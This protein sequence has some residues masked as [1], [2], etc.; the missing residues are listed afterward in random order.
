MRITRH[1]V[2]GRLLPVN[3][4]GEVLLLHGWDPA[5]PSAPY[6]FSIGGAPEGVESLAEAACREMREETGLVVAP[7]EL[8]GPVGRED[9]AFDF[10]MWHLVQDQTFYACA[11]DVSID[12]VSFAGLEPL[13]R[14]CIDRAGWWTPEDL[15]ADGSACSDQLIEI[16]RAAVAA[17]AAVR[18]G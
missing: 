17:V 14:G 3:A 15:A 10:A 13:E 16:M 11:S 1:R 5:R 6:W 9:V 18:R 7:D 8:V 12:E 4:S 2:C